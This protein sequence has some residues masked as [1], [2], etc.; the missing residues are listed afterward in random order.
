MQSIFY[1][2]LTEI[3]FCPCYFFY[4]TYEPSL[5]S[6]ILPLDQLMSKPTVYED[7]I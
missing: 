1:L 6:S 5:G 4:F 3:T 2:S 7:L